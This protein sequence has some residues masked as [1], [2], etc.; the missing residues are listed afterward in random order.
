M[1]MTHEHEAA[2]GGNKKVILTLVAVVL[3]LY[4]GS[5]FILSS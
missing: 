4:I 3:A 5:F 2:R 1:A